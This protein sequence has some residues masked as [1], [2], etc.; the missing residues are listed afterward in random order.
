MSAQI[1]ATPSHKRK[2]GADVITDEKRRVVFRPVL[3]NPHV[4]VLWPTVSADD[5]KLF[6]DLLCSLLQPVG[7]YI[8][9]KSKIKQQKK[10]VT[11]TTSSSHAAEQLQKPTRPDVLNYLTLGF[12]PTTF[13]LEA[14][15]S[16]IFA[17]QS[18]IAPTKS[19]TA[20]SSKKT[21]KH[22]LTAVFVS[23]SDITPAVLLSHFPILCASSSIP[24]RLVQLPR[25]SLA[26]LS[27]ATSIPGLGI[28][29]IRPDCPSASML[30]NALERV[31]LVVVPWAEARLGSS[32]YET[33]KVKQIIT[34]APIMS[35]SSKKNGNDN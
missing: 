8:C 21:S 24:V 5:G 12:N 6:V 20:V 25:G 2:G 14:Q 1:P 16:R 15:V 28:L 13:A 27:Q 32:V 30:F 3:D 7:T 26:R 17:Q 10:T 31:D 9:T 19:T 29:G 11:S 34:S 4:K 22:P 23:R 18:Y 35:S 33:L